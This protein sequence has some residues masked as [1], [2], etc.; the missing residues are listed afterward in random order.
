MVTVADI[1]EM[2]GCKIVDYSV[3]G[4]NIMDGYFMPPAG[5]FPVR[6]D[7]KVG[8]RQINLTLEFK[9][10]PEQCE[11]YVSDFLA[12]LISEGIDFLFPDGFW[13]RVVYNQDNATARKGR[14]Y[15]QHAFRLLGVRHGA[16]ITETLTATENIIVQGNRVT[17]CRLTVSGISGTVTVFGITIS[18]LTGSVVID[19]INGTVTQGNVN[20]F[21]NTD[22]TDF[23]K[24]KPGTNSIVVPSGC[25]VNIEYYPLY[26]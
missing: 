21:G 10:T 23:P 2:Y 24:L 8:M 14:V 25:T 6:Y 20:V 1:G 18:G 26:W 11:E 3:G 7:G 9:G 5:F 12:D 15:A 22:L 4:V 17:P 13:Y 19:G 16:L